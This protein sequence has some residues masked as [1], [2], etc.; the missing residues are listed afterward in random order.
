M[1]FAIFGDIH[2]NLEAFEAVLADAE[3]EGCDRNIC[4]GDIVGYNADTKACVD[5]GREW[6]CQLV[7]GNNDDYAST[8]NLLDNFNPLAESA[9]RWAG[10]RFSEGDKTFLRVLPLF[11]GVGFFTFVHATL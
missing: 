4:L 11:N 5:K 7:K 9:I 10:D 1:R 2:A 6:K 8:L 3:N